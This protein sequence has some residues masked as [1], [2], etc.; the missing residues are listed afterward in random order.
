MY[1]KSGQNWVSKLSQDRSGPQRM[2]SD[3]PANLKRRRSRYG[4]EVHRGHIFFLPVSGGGAQRKQDAN[5]FGIYEI[6]RGWQ[7]NLQVIDP[8]PATAGRFGTQACAPETPI[9]AKGRHLT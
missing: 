3:R 9:A 2:G 8:S 1:R 4:D 6:L 5:V 7:R